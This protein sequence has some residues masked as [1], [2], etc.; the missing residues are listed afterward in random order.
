MIHGRRLIESRPILTRIPDKDLV[1]TDRVATSV[2]GAGRYRFTATRDRDGNYAM[3]YA[4]VGRAFRVRTDKIAGAKL[5]AWWYNPRTGDATEIGEFANKGDHEFIPPNPGELLDW[6]LVLD[7]AARN[8][9]PPGQRA[10]RQA[11]VGERTLSDRDGTN[12]THRDLLP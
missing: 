6:V 8:F 10:P 2:P 7:D 3:V 4:P 1:V 9:P 5:R 11:Q 12:R